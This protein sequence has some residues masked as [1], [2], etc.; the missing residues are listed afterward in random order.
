MKINNKG[1]S[2][3]EIII[4]ITLISMIIVFLL[5]VLITVRYEDQTSKEL[6][7]LKLNQA[8]ITKEI[9]TDFIERELMAVESC[10]DASLRSLDTV[11]SIIKSPN[12]S[13]NITGGSN[14]LKFIYNSEK[15]EDNVGYLLN[16]TYSYTHGEKIHVTGYH[17]G[18]KSIV[19]ETDNPASKEGTAKVNCSGALCVVTINL[20]IIADNGDD[21]G[22]NLSYISRNGFNYTLGT[23]SYYLFKINH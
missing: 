4:S 23:S 5:S 20:P 14:C 16:Y 2:L 15:G 7:K 10:Q 18:N 17:R 1:I 3:V 9:H 11:R 19:R 6:S 21:Y 12:N 22:I 13:L 8:L